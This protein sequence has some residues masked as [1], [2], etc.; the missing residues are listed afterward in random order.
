MTVNIGTKRNQKRNLRTL[1]LCIAGFLSAFCLGRLE[2]GLSKGTLLLSNTSILLIV[3]VC[4]VV[5]HGTLWYEYKKRDEF[6]KAIL[7]KATTF[8]FFVSL[9]GF[10]WYVL[11]QAGLVFPFHMRVYLLIVCLS[12]LGFFVYQTILGIKDEVSS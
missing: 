1:L 8:T 9:L 12:F 2:I 5:S 4:T 6:E 7:D 3:A 11:S 10:P